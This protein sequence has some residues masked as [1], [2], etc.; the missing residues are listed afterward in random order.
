[1]GC[2]SMQDR[3]NTEGKQ[4]GTATAKTVAYYV[5]RHY[6]GDL[7]EWYGAEEADDG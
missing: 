6:H 2:S 4:R 3:S 1:M 5:F 7:Y